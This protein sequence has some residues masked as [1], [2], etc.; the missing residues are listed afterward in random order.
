M[1]TFD[2]PDASVGDGISVLSW[3]RSVAEENQPGADVAPAIFPGACM[4]RTST[5]DQ[6]D[7]TLPVPRQ[8]EICRAAL[9]AQFVIV[10]KFYDI[11]SGLKDLDLR[12]HSDK[13]KQFDDTE[14]RTSL[15]KRFATISTERRDVAARITE[16]GSRVKPHPAAPIVEAALLTILPI[17]GDDLT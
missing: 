12:G 3:L 13:H 14:W 8:L 10:A 15:Q 9:P 11:E 4:G 2:L 7:P 16:L 1:T 17:T 5:D 6:Q